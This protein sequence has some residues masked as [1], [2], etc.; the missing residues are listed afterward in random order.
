MREN[1]QSYQYSGGDNGWM[2]NLFY[3]PVAKYL[4]N[5]LPE[6][7]APNV[8]TLFGFLFSAAPFFVEFTL[9]GTKFENQAANPV[10]KWFFFFQAFCYFMYRLLDEMD[11]KQARKT[12]QS[13]PLGLLF[14]HGLDAF[15]MNF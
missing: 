14:D 11:G 3:N 6:T 8:I 5:F 12:G 10:P 13:S 2:Y 7:L 9:Y 15:S 1:L 4:V